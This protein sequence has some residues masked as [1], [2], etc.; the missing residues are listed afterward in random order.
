M[1]LLMGYV[2]N[3][4]ADGLC[5]KFSSKRLYTCHVNNTRCLTH[6]SR[7]ADLEIPDRIGPLIASSVSLQSDFI[8]SRLP[9]GF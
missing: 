4:V 5:S 7:N 2:V 3:L 9:T 1:L 8:L 6:V